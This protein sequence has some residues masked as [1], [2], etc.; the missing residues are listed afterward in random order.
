MTY[1]MLGLQISKSA[2]YLFRFDPCTAMTDI[3][4]AIQK[5]G[6]DAVFTAAAAGECE[7]YEP[8]R[9]ILNWSVQI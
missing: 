2:P 4:K 7:D 6:A 1:G 3:N 5:Y 8:L 9:A